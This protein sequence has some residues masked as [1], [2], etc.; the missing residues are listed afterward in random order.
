MKRTVNDILDDAN[1]S[2]PKILKSKVLS[3][4]TYL[5]VRIGADTFRTAALRH[6]TTHNLLLRRD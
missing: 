6:L 1:D 2:S 4:D 5:T 3:Y